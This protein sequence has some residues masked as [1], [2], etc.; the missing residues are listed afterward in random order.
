MI[1]RPM[2]GPT[3]YYDFNSPYAYLAA[4]RIDDVLPIRAHWRP[5][6]FGALIR[7]IGKVPWSL[8]GD[9]ERS[10]ACATASSGRPRSA[11]R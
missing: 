7:Q 6:A 1:G 11:F 10:A 2:S 3:F 8:Q 4:H 5:I 9:P